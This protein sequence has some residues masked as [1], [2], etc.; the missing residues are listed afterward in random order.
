MASLGNP[1]CALRGV[2]RRVSVEDVPAVIAND[3]NDG[4][5]RREARPGYQL[6]H[7]LVD[8]GF[9]G[10]VDGDG[11][12][13]DVVYRLDTDPGRTFPRFAKG[14]QV[15]FIVRPFM[16]WQSNGS[17]PFKVIRFSLLSIADES[18]ASKVA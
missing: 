9:D 17:R 4:N 8:T 7:V 15:E 6:A 16:V 3:G 5:P 13:A 2:I 18:A 11:G 1:I 10:Y 12:A 14:E